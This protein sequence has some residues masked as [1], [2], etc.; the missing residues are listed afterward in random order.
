MISLAVANATDGKKPGSHGQITILLES[1]KSIRTLHIWDQTAG[2]SLSTHIKPSFLVPI[3]ATES[4]TTPIPHSYIKTIKYHRNAFP[5]CIFTPTL[6]R[7]QT[8]PLPRLPNL[9]DIGNVMLI[10]TAVHHSNPIQSQSSIDSLH[11]G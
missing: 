8:Q 11:V 1:N 10:I 4:N 6:Y 5:I 7:L 3:L 2:C 9:L